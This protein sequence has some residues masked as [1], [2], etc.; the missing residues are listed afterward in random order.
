MP[1]DDQ[2]VLVTGVASAPAS[3]TIPGNGQIQPKTIFAT[4][5]G[6]GAASP[7]LPCMK[8]IS[9]G[10]KTVGIYPTT[11]PVAAGGSADVSWFPHIGQTGIPPVPGQLL[12]TY[13]GAHP[14]ADFTTN[15]TTYVQSNYPTNTTFTK[16]SATSCLDIRA[17]ADYTT[18]P[19][20]D[21]IFL[22]IFIDGVN[23]EACG[24]HTS[25]ANSFM[26]VTVQK[27]QGLGNDSQPPLAAGAHTV[28]LATAC[29]LG[30]NITMRSSTSVDL[31]ILEFEP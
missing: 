19:A 10:G 25:I 3:F 6:S 29:L 16:V 1:T 27:V 31:E 28:Y 13:A 15:S 30:N 22:S 24:F 11:S 17:T 26:S 20:N 8:V 12:S 7:F 5:D 21:I 9:D 18:G 23:T 14:A 2:Q 4:F